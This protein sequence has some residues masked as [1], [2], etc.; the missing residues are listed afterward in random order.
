MPER[1]V[2][3]EAFL[4]GA[5]WPGAL[6]APLAGDASFRRYE[7]IRD[8]ARRAVLMDAPPAHEDVR[9]FAA[10]ARYLGDLGLAAP[11]ILA[12]DEAQGFLLL[13]D[14]GDDLFTRVLCQRAD[15]AV[16]YAAAIDVLV[17]AQDR[18]CALA[19]PVYDE[20]L[21][22]AE[23]DLLIDWFLPA[24]SGAP[25]P[26]EARAAYRDAW[27]RVLPAA[28]VWP[29]RLVLRDYHADNLIWL[30]DR[31]GLRRCGLLD[32]QDA[33]IG[34]TAYDL[35]SLLEDAR[36]DV[37]PA[38]VRRSLDR[39]LTLTGADRGAF[40]AAYAV[41]GAQRNAKIIGIFTRLWKRDGK[42]QYLDL[43]PRV[44]A[45]LEGDLG[46]A[47][48]EPMRGWFDRHVPPA[49]RRRP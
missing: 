42:A 1:D 11:D 3:I 13:E 8:G 16:L 20:A 44:W 31:P 25:T 6:R 28:H 5:G 46:H 26:D 14:L 36:R 35:V 2:A 27:R 33:V 12:A 37:A 7:R 34:P 38:T 15:E 39:Y 32:F 41:L 45:H 48:L 17:A 30:P 29:A 47:A 24:V 40:R 19:L 43:I 23:A 49:L 22:L 21:L 9:P 18:A 10:V 4:A